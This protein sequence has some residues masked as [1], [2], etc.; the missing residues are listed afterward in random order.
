MKGMCIGFQ[1]DD[2]GLGADILFD[3]SII[4]STND[5]KP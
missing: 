5:P 4:V 2:M 3:R 1:P